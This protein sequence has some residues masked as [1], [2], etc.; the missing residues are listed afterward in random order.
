MMKNVIIVL[1]NLLSLTI[2]FGAILLV[3]NLIGEEAVEPYIVSIAA[4]MS[5]L[6][7][8]TR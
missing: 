8:Y 6:S 2:T 5:F 1:G 4:C 7:T 3:L